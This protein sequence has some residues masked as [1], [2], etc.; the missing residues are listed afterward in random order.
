MTFPPGRIEINVRIEEIS[1]GNYIWYYND[2]AG[3]DL[4]IRVPSHVGQIVF[5]LDVDS[6]RQYVF[7]PPDIEPVGGCKDLTTHPAR[8]RPDHVIVYD[9]QQNCEYVTVGKV[10]LNVQH[11]L[12]GLGDPVTPV[13]LRST[14]PEVTNTGGITDPPPRRSI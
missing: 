8:V 1:T 11:V 6:A 13:K 10:F 12:S 4:S 7:D 9:D 14:D 2:L 5:R 3:G